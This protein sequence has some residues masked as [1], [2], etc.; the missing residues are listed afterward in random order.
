[1]QASHG[2]AVSA[3][4]S[5]RFVELVFPDQ[6]NHYGTLFGGSALSMMG[7]AAFVAATRRA[8]RAVVMATSDKVEF[9]DPVRVGELVELTARVERVG[10]SSMT[11]AVEVIAEALISGDRRTAMRGSF[12]MVAVDEQGRPTPVAS[13]PQNNL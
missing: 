6:A 5:T 11:V 1:M 4:E 10:R 8:R 2:P 12:E 7:K 9:H 3:V 13:F